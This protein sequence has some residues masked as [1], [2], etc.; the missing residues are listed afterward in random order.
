MA[1]IK[2]KVG[3]NGQISLPKSLMKRYNIK[4]GD[5]IYVKLEVSSKE[6]L[7]VEQIIEKVREIRGSLS[8]KKRLTIGELKTV[9]LEGEF[10]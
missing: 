10:V 7:K 4:E 1:E 2:L 9:E 6:K 8:P 5:V 3:P